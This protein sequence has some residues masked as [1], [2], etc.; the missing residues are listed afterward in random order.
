MVKKTYTSTDIE[1]LKGIEPVQKRPGMYTDTSSPNHLLQEVI[2]NCVDESIAGFCDNIDITVTKDGFF[3][4]KDDGRGMP[5]DT[6]PEYKKSGVEVIMTNLHSGAKFSN[7]NYKYSGGL[8][9]VGVS[10]VSA[11]SESLDIEIQRSGDDKLY[12]ISFEKGLVSKKLNSSSKATK[13][14]HGTLI[15]FKPDNQYFDNPEIQINKLVKLIEAKSI[16]QPGLK[17]TIKDEKYGIGEKV[18][19]HTGSLNDYLKSS[20][21]NDYDIYPINPLLLKLDN[22]DYELTAAVC[23][24]ENNLDPIQDSYVNLIPTSEGGTHVNSLKSAI[25]DAVRSFAMSHKMLPKNIRI[26]S[27]DLWKNTS[28]LI[29]IKMSDPQF[30]GQTKNRLQSTS[31]ANK[32]TN[33]LK[34]R[35]E[36][37][38]N[39]HTDTAEC[40]CNI[41]IQNAQHRLANNI[42]KKPKQSIKSLILPSRLSD[43][44]SRDINNNEL[45]LVEGDS[46]GGSAKQARDRNFQAILPLRG[47]NFKHLGSFF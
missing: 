16:L 24:H 45:F 4:V 39:N 6:H 1:V 11:L 26:M 17:L 3:I 21:N 46:A 36:I 31:I 5:V 19:C 22:N 38:L 34:D 9:G 8:H 29:S 42:N 2:D 28:F 43:C 13:N 32:L 10:V 47:K 25:I 41:A 23:W 14:S 33:N 18:Y 20:L 40:I 15:K 30:I 44:T 27:D 7:K 12:K 37:W 35:L